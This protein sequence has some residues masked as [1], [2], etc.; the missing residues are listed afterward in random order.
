MSPDVTVERTMELLLEAI[1]AAVH[2]DDGAVA[3]A[4]AQAYEVLALLPY[5]E[6]LEAEYV[7]DL[8]VQ[9]AER[10]AWTQA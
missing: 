1:D 3:L 8:K 7:R 9:R 6:E 2:R 4:F 5:M 10:D